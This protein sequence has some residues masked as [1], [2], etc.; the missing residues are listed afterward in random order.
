[1][2]PEFVITIGKETVTAVLVIAAPMLIIAMTI[3]ISISLF[4]T[5]TQIRDQTLTFIPKI[6]GIIIAIIFFLPYMLGTLI[7]FATKIFTLG[8]YIV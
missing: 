4:Q 1:M 7:A 3:G 2:T 6:V 8:R 5:V